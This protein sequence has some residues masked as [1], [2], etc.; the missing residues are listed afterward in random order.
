MPRKIYGMVKM[1]GAYTY[2]QAAALYCNPLFPAPGPAREVVKA[3][4]NVNGVARQCYSAYA[5]LVYYG[6]SADGAIEKLSREQNALSSGAAAVG[7]YAIIC[8][9]YGFAD[10]YDE[11]L[12]H[13]T[14]RIP[15]ISDSDIKGASTGTHAIFLEGARLGNNGGKRVWVFDQELV[16]RKLSSD[17]L[18]RTAAAATFGRYAVFAGAYGACAYDDNLVKLSLSGCEDFLHMGNTAAV[19]RNWLSFVVESSVWRYDVNFVL[20]KYSSGISNLFN[21]EASIAAAGQYVIVAGAYTWP[22]NGA[23]STVRA[24][25]QNGVVIPVED[26]LRP[27]TS[28]GAISAGDYALFA[29]GRDPTGVSDPVEVYD[30]NLVKTYAHRLSAVR[31]GHVCVRLGNYILIAGGSNKQESV[32]R[33]AVDV[34]Q[35]LERD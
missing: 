15:G 14:T 28:L 31:S 12:N 13:T 11:E 18:P 1:N 5:D 6:S 10:I 7:R 23:V 20:R 21:G 9:Y 29:G 25:D 16:M 32:S 22:G 30:R 19:A 34:F 24:L 4:C 17:G 8:D 3:Y 33:R 27:K 35:I 26:L 2:R